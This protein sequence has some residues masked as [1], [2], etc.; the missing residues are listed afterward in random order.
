MAGA[1]P[2][3]RR[4]RTPRT[5]PSKYL[6][7]TL[8][9]GAH[10]SSRILIPPVGR[11]ARTTQTTPCE[12]VWTT[13]LFGAH[14]SSRPLVASVHRQLVLD[15]SEVELLEPHPSDLFAL[16]SASM[17][18]STSPRVASTSPKIGHRFVLFLRFGALRHMCTTRHGQAYWNQP[19]E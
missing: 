9:W 5:T 13:M 15:H 18:P 2:V 8:L 6:R 3:G 11:W 17:L 19:F 4:T 1:P 7:T 12:Y 14:S 10:S 16:H